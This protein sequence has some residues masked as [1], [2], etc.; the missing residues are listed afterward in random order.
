MIA[1]E[2]CHLLVALL[3]QGC[4]GGRPSNFNVVHNVL[5]GRPSP[6]DGLHRG[7]HHLRT[8]LLAA[9][10]PLF[11]R[12]RLIPGHVAVGRG[13]TYGGPRKAAALGI[14][15]H[16]SASVTGD[17][18]P[19]LAQQHQLR[20]RPYPQLFGQ[21]LECQ[22][23]TERRCL[24]VHASISLE[25]ALV[26]VQRNKEDFE[27]EALLAVPPVT[28]TKKAREVVNEE[29]RREVHAE[30]AVGLQ[31]RQGTVQGCRALPLRLYLLCAFCTIGQFVLTLLECLLFHGGT[32]ALDDEVPKAARLHE[33]CVSE[34]PLAV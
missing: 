24:P 6:N 11:V 17:G 29:M 3:C 8:A 33:P 25:G 16:G 9:S 22:W 15:G 10:R 5:L 32:P 1:L 7:P 28:F 30:D 27:V 23:R 13:C 18:R 21:P 4:P 34:R 2:V 26:G 20:H 19:V 31:A 12:R 14:L